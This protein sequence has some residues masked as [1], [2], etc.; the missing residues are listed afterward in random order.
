MGPWA[1]AV[2]SERPK[3]LD[4]NRFE[5]LRTIV[6]TVAELP[7]GQRAG[8]LKALCGADDLLRREAESLLSHEQ[9]ELRAVPQGELLQALV[10]A[11]AIGR[12]PCL[13]DLDF[14]M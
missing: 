12:P 7:R 3:S 6:L 14:R 8:R 4:G 9:D 1:R 11:G 5:R 10:M 2:E 13:P